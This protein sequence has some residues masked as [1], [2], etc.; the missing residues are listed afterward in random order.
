MRNIVTGHWFRWRANVDFNFGR[1]QDTA[2]CSDSSGVLMWFNCISLFHDLSIGQQVVCLYAGISFTCVLKSTYPLNLNQF[3]FEGY[4][5]YLFFL[6]II[7][8]LP[9]FLKLHPSLRNNL[10]P[11]SATC[12][13]WIWLCIQ[14]PRWGKCSRPK[15]TLTLFFLGH[16]HWFQNGHVI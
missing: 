16:N 10:C 8:H 14:I 15:L 13:Q 7:I 6:P 12:H 11:L 4:R 9:S 1:K 5:K 3:I 2:P